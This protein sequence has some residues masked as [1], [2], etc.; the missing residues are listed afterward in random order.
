M[1]NLI[2]VL[3][4]FVG[5]NCAFYYAF[6]D[7]EKISLKTY[8][9]GSMRHLGKIAMFIVAIGLFFWF[10]LFLTWLTK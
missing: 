1:M 2:Y 8:L 6:A 7:K 9:K 4:V 10:P 5:M 3:L